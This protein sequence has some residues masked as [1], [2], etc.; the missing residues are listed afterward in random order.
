MSQ[1]KSVLFDLDGTIIYSHPGIVHAMRHCLETLGYPV[2]DDE[3]LKACVGPPPR[4]SLREFFHI[5][6]EQLEKAFRI[7]RQYYN[8][9]GISEYTPVPGMC[10]L[11]RRLYGAGWKLYTGTS[12]V[13]WATKKILKELDILQYFTA[14]GAA[15]DDGVTRQSK[16]DVLR[17]TL[18]T[19]GAPQ[20][21]VLIGDRKYDVLG[22]HEAGIDCIAI[23]FG[24]GSR[25]ELAAC[26]PTH[27][28]DSIADIEAILKQEEADV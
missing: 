10:E 4:Q 8:T 19:L 3:A 26:R 24:Y 18:D 25:E 15:D 13:E 22:A 5:P 28:A 20:P 2:P 12:K 6:E 11:I 23:T 17:Y 16:P 1:Y 27:I 14:L 9:I 7:N 21:A